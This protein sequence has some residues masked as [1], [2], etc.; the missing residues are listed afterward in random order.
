[1]NIQPYRVLG[2]ASWVL[3]SQNRL[4][5]TNGENKISLAEHAQSW[6]G[7]T[8]DPLEE[9]HEAVEVQQWNVFLL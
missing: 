6:N 2:P 1:V 9:R 4:D 7:P 3:V 5:V 8:A